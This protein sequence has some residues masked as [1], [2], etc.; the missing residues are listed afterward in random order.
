MRIRVIFESWEK[1]ENAISRSLCG[2]INKQNPKTNPISGFIL[3][4]SL[5]NLISERH[6]LGI[7]NSISI[8]FNLRLDKDK[9]VGISDIELMEY[10]PTTLEPSK[11]GDITLKDEISDYVIIE[12]GWEDIIE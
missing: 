8:R 12:K 7:G 1:L 2:V 6:L 9:V 5:S 4:K 3:S 10:S 11:I